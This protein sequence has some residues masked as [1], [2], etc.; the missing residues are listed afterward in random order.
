[1]GSGLIGASAARLFAAVGHEVAL[2]NSR[3]PSSLSNLV[4]EIGDGARA[5]TVEEAARFGEVVVVAVP[6]KA[7]PDLPA[8]AFAGKVVADANN[9]YPGRDG[10]F[11][12]LDDDRT[13]S[14]ELLAE[15]LAVKAFNTMYYATLATE[16]RPDTPR[17]ERPV[18]FVRADDPDAKRIVSRFSGHGR[19]SVGARTRDRPA[20]RR[21]AGAVRERTRGPRSAAALRAPS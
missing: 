15:H 6:L 12:A 9:Y 11:E 16:G 21:A 7:Y 20:L 13:T 3:G 14:S 8:E 19:T 2:A 18:L 4:G 1:M 5:A 17:D 10:S